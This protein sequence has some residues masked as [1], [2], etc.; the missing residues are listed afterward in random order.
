[1]PREGND[2]EEEKGP[3]AGWDP[4]PHLL[5]WRGVT[6]GARFPGGVRGAWE[7][8]STGLDPGP[9]TGLLGRQRP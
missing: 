2:V 8:R 7:S 6:G 4:A 5:L 9:A 1:M 3:W